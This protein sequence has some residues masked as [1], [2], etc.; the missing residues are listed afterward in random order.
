MASGCRT[1]ATLVLNSLLIAVLAPGCKKEAITPPILLTVTAMSPGD[2]PLVGGTG[3]TITGS[4][5]IDVTDVSIGGLALGSFS[6]ATPTLIT[7]MTPTAASPG[8]KDV[9]VTSRRYGSGTCARCFTYNPVLTVASVSPPSGPL[10]GGTD[11]TITGTNFT[12]VTGATLGGIELTNRTTVTVTEIRATTPPGGSPGATDVVVTSSSHGTGA[13]TDCF[14]YLSVGRWTSF[15]AMLTPRGQTVAGVING[16]LYVAGGY[17]PLTGAV[18]TLEAYDPVAST[19]TAKAP[20]PIAR[21]G[22]VAGVVNG[23]LYVAGGLVGDSTTVDAYDPATNTWTTKVATM[24]AW[25][26][27]AAG[28]VLNGLLYVAGGHDYNNST[29]LASVEAY[30]PAANTWTT[31]APM[32]MPVEYGVASVVNGIL[33]VVG[34]GVVWAYDPV[35]D[36]WT[37]KTPMPTA[38][39]HAV[40][41]VLNDTLYVVGGYVGATATVL[42]TV[43]AYDPVRNTWTTKA[44]MPTPRYGAA[45]GVVSGILYVAGG[46]D[47]TGVALTRL[48]GYQP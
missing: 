45:A 14:T 8:A 47:S 35:S 37:T 38:R 7:G 23:I 21:Y 19:W 15:P 31:K 12:N 43:E 28:A 11:V 48:E 9:V 25:H 6:V 18:A 39:N 17:V 1:T 41:G 44:R 26:G 36:M 33:C 40:A 5:F 22:A 46:F 20:M 29:I 27:A 2:G 13:C 3:V 34:G 16:I 4:N 10:A 42:A 24:H 32:P 30:D